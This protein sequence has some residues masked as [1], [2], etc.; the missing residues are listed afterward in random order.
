MERSEAQNQEPFKLLRRILDFQANLATKV[1]C[2]LDIA[3]TVAQ[4]KWRNGRFLLDDTSVSIPPS[5]FQEALTELH[6]LLP[7]GGPEQAALNRLLGS[8]FVT[9]Q[10]ADVLLDDLSTD[11]ETFIQRVADA[12]STDPSSLAYLLHIVLLPVF[13]K[14]AMPYQHLIEKAAWRRGTCP[15]CGSEPW[16]ARLAHNSGRRILACSLCH[17][18]WSFDRLRC[19]FCDSDSQPYLRYFTA[20]NDTAHRVD[21]CDRCLCYLKTVDE[22][23]LGHP[24]D[25]VVEDVTTAHLDA[26][27]EEQG[28]HRGLMVSEQG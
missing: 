17:T 22:R 12:T 8:R 16:M 14:Q 6:P 7:P 18:E 5:L 21:C 19:P 20:D 28:Y 24:A 1:E 23:L 4:E 9:S 15:V 26:S 27:A 10:H 2:Q 13:K 11:G 3:P 25:L